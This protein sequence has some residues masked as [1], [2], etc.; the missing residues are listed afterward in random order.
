MGYAN[1]TL[2]TSVVEIG[3]TEIRGELCKRSQNKHRKSPRGTAIMANL[4]AINRM[5][6]LT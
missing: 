5:G 1:L 6:L 4:Q 3:G 2:A